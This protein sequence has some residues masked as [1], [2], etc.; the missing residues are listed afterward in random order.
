M[1]T[2]LF[3]EDVGEP[4]ELEIASKY[5]NVET[6]RSRYYKNLVIGRYSVLPY[7]CELEKDLE[8]SDCNLINTYEEHKFIANFDWYNH[9]R[10]FTPMP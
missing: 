3:R 4:E 10:G 2:I 5:F 9:V 8:I 7:Y 1:I 6:Q